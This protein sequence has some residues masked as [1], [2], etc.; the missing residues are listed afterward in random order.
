[1]ICY[2]KDDG[3]F[4]FSNKT[5]AELE[6]SGFT[7]IE[8]SSTFRQASLTETNGDAALI[9]SVQRAKFLN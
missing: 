8:M 3:S 9:L 7:N 6:A 4:A 2:A 5:K 1:L